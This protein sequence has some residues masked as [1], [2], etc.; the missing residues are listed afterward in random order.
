LASE[1]GLVAVFALRIELLTNFLHAS[2]W[3]SGML[4]STFL[5]SP[6]PKPVTV[7]LCLGR[8][9][10]GPTG[11]LRSE[12]GALV[13]GLLSRGFLAV[14][15]AILKMSMAEK[16]ALLRE[17]RCE[18]GEGGVEGR[19]M[20]GSEKQRSRQTRGAAGVPRGYKADAFS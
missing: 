1:P 19:E 15:V 7:R 20:V 9:N 8:V 3:G 12:S 11:P 2:L 4:A 16:R 18:S 14:S 13:E 17:C 5:I 6:G 10:C